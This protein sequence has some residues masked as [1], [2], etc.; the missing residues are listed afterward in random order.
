[1]GKETNSLDSS[2]YPYS[3]YKLTTIVGDEREHR[4]LTDQHLKLGIIMLR[5]M[6]DGRWVHRRID[7]AVHN[8]PV[9]IS[10]TKSVDFTLPG[11][12]VSPLRSPDGRRLDYALLA[13]LTKWRIVNVDLRDERGAALPLIDR[14]EY[15][16]I[17]VAMLVT[18]AHLV[19]WRPIATSPDE[20]LVPQSIQ[21]EFSEIVGRREEIALGVCEALIGRRPGDD[22]RDYAWRVLLAT[23]YVFMSL[24]WTLARGFMFLVPLYDSIGERRVIKFSYDAYRYRAKTHWRLPVRARYALTKAIHPGSCSPLLGTFDPL[25]YRV[26]APPPPATAGTGRLLLGIEWL[27]GRST[28]RPEPAATPVALFTL[29]GPDGGTHTIVV[30]GNETIQTLP[31]GEWRVS[32]PEIDGYERKEDVS[33]RTFVINNSRT[34]DLS[35]AY[36]E[37]EKRVVS[38]RPPIDSPFDSRLLWLLEEV[39]ITSRRVMF[40]LTLYKHGSAHFQFQAPDGFVITRIKLSVAGSKGRIMDMS[41][42]SSQRADVYAFNANLP[43][44]AIVLANVRP[45]SDT[46]VDL[47][48]VTAVITA[49]IVYAYAIWHAVSGSA[50]SGV[51]TLLLASPGALAAFA[52]QSP[53]EVIVSRMTAGLRYF[54]LLPGFIAFAAAGTAAAWPRA[55]AGKVVELILANLAVWVAMLAWLAHRWTLRPRERYSWQGPNRSDG[56]ADDSSSMEIDPAHDRHVEDRLHEIESE[57]SR[58]CEGDV[59]WA[60]YDIRERLRSESQAMPSDLRDEYLIERFGGLKASRPPSIFVDSGEVAP[61]FIGLCALQRH[62]LRKALAKGFTSDRTV[63]NVAYSVSAAGSSSSSRIRARNRAASAP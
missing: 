23:S 54:S 2:Y 52:A 37:K 17:G 44:R 9:A 42:R 56:K 38:S 36:R 28:T 33:P 16:P 35:F 26:Q 34:T 62:E 6:N 46:I 57:I 20:I 30:V 39:G 25:A 32:P 8:D 50:P 13:I 51:I 60:A 3:S 4:R 55:T 22:Q 15:T 10:R 53:R 12:Y 45:R 31:V 40:S 24:A 5:L 58:K 63:A 21:T 19:A 48:W 61:T 1:V 14:R 59:L 27:T 11:D 47:S 41:A 29:V 49:L 43:T 7:K 18:L